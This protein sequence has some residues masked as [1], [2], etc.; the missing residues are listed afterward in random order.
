MG[1]LRRGVALPL[2]TQLLLLRRE[3]R[4]RLLLRSHCGDRAAQELLRLSGERGVRRVLAQQR[5]LFLGKQRRARL[6]IALQTLLRLGGALR[7]AHDVRHVDS[8]QL[9]L[10]FSEHFH[11]GS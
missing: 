11:A 8:P 5:T 9:A 6:G 10:S 1:R 2:F 4:R 3:L 7:G